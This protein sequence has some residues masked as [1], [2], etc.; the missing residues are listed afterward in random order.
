MVWWFV[1]AAVVLLVAFAL[2]RLDTRMK[3]REGYT[4]ERQTGTYDGE[5]GDGGG[6]GGGMS[7]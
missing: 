4:S 2:W 7:G 6:G 3:R 1:G 5:G